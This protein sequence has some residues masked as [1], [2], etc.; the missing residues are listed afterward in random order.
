MLF[1]FLWDSGDI[2]INA[3]VKLGGW[4]HVKSSSEEK[5]SI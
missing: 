2:E 5:R 4:M 1:E 3:A